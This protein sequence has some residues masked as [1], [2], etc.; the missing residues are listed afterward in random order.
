MKF[1]RFLLLILAVVVSMQSCKKDPDQ[2]WKVDVK[3]P[4]EKVKITDISKEFFDPKVPTSQFKSKYP[5]FQGSVSDEFLEK[6]R[7][8][9]DEIKVYQT[10]LSKIDVNKVSIDLTALFARI[11]HYFPKFV[12]PKVYIFSSSTQMYEEPVIYDPQSGFLFI[13]ISCFLGQ[14]DPVYKGIEAYYT[15]AMNPEN[16]LPKVSEAIAYTMIPFDRN[17]QKF[18]D[19]V[20]YNGK[21]MILQDAFLPNVPDHLKMGHTQAQYEWSKANEV[22]IWNFFVED[23]LLFSP[24]PRLVNRFIS[25]GPFSK[26]YTEIDQKSSPQVGVFTGWQIC[27]KFFAKYPETKLIDFL[28]MSASDIFNKSEYKPKD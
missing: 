18:I 28:N 20:I 5:W 14:K 23:N 4:S 17:A 9:A 24:D 22:N 6:R 8:N 15:T 2:I 19:I 11:R 16:V 1:F 10:A 3:V 13:D 7:V 27:R 25:P 21:L 26:F 12:D